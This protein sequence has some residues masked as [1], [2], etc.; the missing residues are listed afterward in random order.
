MKAYY[1]LVF[2]L[3]LSC[4]KNTSQ[5]GGL[6]SVKNNLT[7]PSYQVPN[8]QV[9]YEALSLDRLEGVWTLQGKLYSGYAVQSYPNGSIKARIGFFNGKKQGISRGYYPD[10][11][12]RQLTPYHQNLV[13][14]EA[15]N[16]FGTEEHSLLAVRNFYLGKLHG[17]FKKWYKSGQLFKVMNYNMGKEEGMQQAFNEN[18]DIYAN[19]EAKNGRSFG[20]KRSM[21]CF[22]LAD[23]KIVSDAE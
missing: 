2:L 19:Y 13:H 23:E 18:G 7:V 3:I 11:Q 12:L 4:Q 21:L 14:G 22:A 10:G 17:T 1:S 15:R 20:L 6:N 16:W 9:S 8:I 5:A